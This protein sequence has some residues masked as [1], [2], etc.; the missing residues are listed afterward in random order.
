M[1]LIVREH[2]SK[3]CVSNASDKENLSNYIGQKLCLQR[4]LWNNLPALLCQYTLKF[5]QSVHLE[6]IEI[7]SNNLRLNMKIIAKL[8]TIDPRRRNTRMKY[9]RVKLVLIYIK[10]SRKD[11][12]M[13]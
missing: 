1:N 13:I 2:F 11:T 5:T 6:I 9:F 12:K 7:C 10:L 3:L 8:C 4:G